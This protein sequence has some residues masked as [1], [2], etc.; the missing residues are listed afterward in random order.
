MKMNVMVIIRPQ[1]QPNDLDC[2]LRLSRSIISTGARQ[3]MTF[4]LVW[5]EILTIVIYQKSFVH[6]SI[7]QKLINYSIA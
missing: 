6:T 5:A 3:N 4:L 1:G 2:G 7:L